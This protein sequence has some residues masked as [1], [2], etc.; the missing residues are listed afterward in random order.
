MNKFSLFFKF[1]YVLFISFGFF[2]FKNP[3]DINLSETFCNISIYHIFGC[4]RLGRDILSLFCYGSIV[5]LILAIPSK[6]F[7][8][9]ISLILSLLTYS[10]GRFM[11][12]LISSLSSVFLSIPSLLIALVVIYSLGK[13]FEV[14]LLSI[15]LS[16]WAM[17]YET[18]HSKISEISNSGYVYV[19]KNFGASN[20]Y[21]FKNHIF[22]QLIPILNVLFI[23]GIPSIIMTIAIY[24]YMGINFGSD[25]FGPGLGE[26][27][28]FSRDYFHKSP[29][30]VVLPIIGIFLLVN[31]FNF[32][33]IKK[34][35]LVN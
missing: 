26:Q 34:K 18:I 22:P 21:I 33:E 28:S 8:I 1:I 4:D 19:S 2:L 25:T 15:V 16:D 6:I 23:T 12:L 10:G 14:F 24:S 31:V 7:S 17:S 27:I 5:T 30:S 3:N 9:I 13:N 11:G 35:N 32:Q 29:L 20:F